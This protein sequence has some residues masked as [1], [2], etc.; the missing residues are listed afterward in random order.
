MKH[1]FLEFCLYFLPVSFSVALMTKIKFLH[2]FFTCMFLVLLWYF[3]KGFFFPNRCE[4]ILEQIEKNQTKNEDFSKKEPF[5]S[6]I[7]LFFKGIFIKRKNND[8]KTINFVPQRMVSKK[9]DNKGNQKPKKLNKSKITKVGVFRR[10]WNFLVS[11]I[12]PN[13]YPVITK[14]YLKH[15]IN[16][17]LKEAKQKRA[18]TP[19][20]NG[21]KKTASEV[22]RIIKKHPQST[23]ILYLNKFSF[24]SIVHEEPKDFQSLHLQKRVSLKNNSLLL[25]KF[26]T[27]RTN[28]SF[29]L[30]SS[31]IQQTSTMLR[32][33]QAQKKRGHMS[34][35]LSLKHTKQVSSAL[36]E[37]HNLLTNEAEKCFE[38]LRISKE[39][40]G[41]MEKCKDWVFNEMIRIIFTKNINN[42]VET[43]N[44]LEGHYRKTLQE[45]QM[46]YGDLR[47]S[48]TNLGENQFVSLNDLISFG[49]AQ[50]FWKV[51]SSEDSMDVMKITAQLAQSI[52]DRK[53]LDVCLTVQGYNIAQIRYNISFF[54]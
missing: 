29:D 25:K 38:D 47:K 39:I 20:A 26:S 42:L 30:P 18:K 12:R 1:N 10:I 49:S 45:F 21:N 13:K 8:L 40:G 48:Q 35:S 7:F 19:P 4:D 36:L 54:Q 32:H 37:K 3:V 43:N 23:K 24:S 46:L 51:Y 44:I 16:Q 31:S 5:F 53:H 6:K 34:R 41:W 14:P 33:S 27:S 52:R 50:A 2:F 15:V 11:I 17:A 22:Y 9:M 28:V